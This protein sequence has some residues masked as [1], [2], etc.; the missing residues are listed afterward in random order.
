MLVDVLGWP[1]VERVWLPDWLS[2]PSAVLDR[3]TAAM[4][5]PVPP[6]E[7]E[8]VPTLPPTPP[9]VPP[10]SRGSHDRE[11]VGPAWFVPWKPP[12]LGQLDA[13]QGAEIR[14]ALVAAVVA[15]GPIHADRLAR[16]VA[17]AFGLTRVSDARREAILRHLPREVRR[18]EAEPVLWPPTLRDWTGYRRTPEGVDRPL[19]HVPLREIGNAMVALS[20]ASAGMDRDELHRATLAVFGFRR[21]T[22][23]TA[24]R[25]DSAVAVAVREGRLRTDGHTVRP[26]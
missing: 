7:V 2:Q 26:T 23:S 11:G 17:N 12:T 25:L 10:S 20:G 5:A 21:L 6:A 14:R 19:E 8:L 16:L 9:L 15:E 13:A 1:A 3:L 4:T 18:D 22:A 24:L